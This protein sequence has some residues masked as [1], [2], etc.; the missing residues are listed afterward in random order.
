MEDHRQP[1]ANN[2]RCAFGATCVSTESVFS[3]IHDARQSCCC[4]RRRVILLTLY[5]FV[6]LYVVVVVIAVVTVVP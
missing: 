5:Y 4:W 3:A 6:I 1:A 2:T